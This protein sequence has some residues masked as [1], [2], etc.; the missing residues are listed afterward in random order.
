[1]PL[2]F[3]VNLQ[4]RQAQLHYLENSVSEIEFGMDRSVHRKHGAAGRGHG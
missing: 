4:S 2:P 1:L 3:L